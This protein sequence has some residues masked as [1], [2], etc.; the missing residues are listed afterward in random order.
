MN[1][2]NLKFEDF[3]SVLQWYIFNN[4]DQASKETVVFIKIRLQK[5]Q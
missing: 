2:L 3:S 1:H 5:K 4:Q